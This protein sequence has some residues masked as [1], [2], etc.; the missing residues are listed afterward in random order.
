MPITAIEFEKKLVQYAS[1]TLTKLKTGNLFNIDSSFE[2]LDECIDYYNELLNKKGIFI[3]LITVENRTMIYIYQKEKL[4]NLFNNNKIKNLFKR[5]NYS[6]TS[7]ESL[8]FDLQ[9]RMSKDNFP[10][11]IGI[12]LGYPLTDVISFIE[13][14]KHLYIGYWKVYSHVNNCKGTFIKY[15]KCTNE[16]VKRFISGKRLEQL[17]QNI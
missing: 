12:F 15:N 7:P 9:K 17:C 11:E 3:D 6:C 2:Q 5:Y 1:P 16:M 13:G 4:M 8:I 14:K 10:H